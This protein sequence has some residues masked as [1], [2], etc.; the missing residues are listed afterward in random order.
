MC[1]FSDRKIDHSIAQMPITSIRNYDSNK[2]SMFSKNTHR[3]LSWACFVDER[4]KTSLSCS[5]C[6]CAKIKSS[7]LVDTL[8]II[9]AVRNAQMFRK[10]GWP[11]FSDNRRSRT[12]HR[13]WPHQA[14]M[15]NEARISENSEKKCDWWVDVW[16]RSLCFCHCSHVYSKCRDKLL[17]L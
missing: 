8:S 3:T 15:A 16:R 14:H 10:S 2:K 9:F 13:R 11:S 12:Q 1:L 6:S 7:F 5:K 17:H 4:A